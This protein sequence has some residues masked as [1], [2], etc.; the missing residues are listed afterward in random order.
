MTRESIRFEYPK[1][2]KAEWREGIL[3]DAESEIRKILGKLKS[4]PGAKGTATRDL[5]A[6]QRR[7]EVFAHEKANGR[8][9]R[10]AWTAAKATVQTE[11]PKLRKEATYEMAMRRGKRIAA[12]KK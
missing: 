4:S 2:R 3:R 6:F 8:S 10:L 7:E 5:E 11:F 9:D 12:H 1:E